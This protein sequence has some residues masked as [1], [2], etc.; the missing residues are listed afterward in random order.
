MANGSPSRKELGDLT[1]KAHD[2]ELGLYL[3]ELHSRFLQW[4]EGEI[5][6]SELSDLIH[7]FHDGSARA[8]YKTYSNLD[9]EQLVARAIGIGLLKESEVSD[10]IRERLSSSIDFYTDHYEIDQ[11]DPLSKLRASHTSGA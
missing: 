5:S 11:G 1:E 3:A 7:E 4:R 6:P 2:R 8:V 10:E 9:R